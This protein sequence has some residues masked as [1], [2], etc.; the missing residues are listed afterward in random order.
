MDEPPG[1]ADG[2]RAGGKADE[3]LARGAR[4][5]DPDARALD[6]VARHRRQPLTCALQPA[7]ELGQ[8]TAGLAVFAADDGRSYA[9]AAVAVVTGQASR[10]AL[11]LR[12]VC[13][14]AS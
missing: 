10:R 2:Q 5:G 13:L 12:L 8:K 7:V 6:L 14:R 4:G 9:G 3:H 1:R 11:R